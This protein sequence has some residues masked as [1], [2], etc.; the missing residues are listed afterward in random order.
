MDEHP[1]L[2]SGHGGW[3]QFIVFDYSLFAPLAPVRCFNAGILR[4][5][6]MLLMIVSHCYF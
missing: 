5:Q 6:V 1:T 3:V 4:I 2:F